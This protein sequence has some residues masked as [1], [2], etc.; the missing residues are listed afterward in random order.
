MVKQEAHPTLTLRRY[1]HAS[2]DV[3]VQT[4]HDAS[5]VGRLSREEDSC[6]AGGRGI[7]PLLGRGHGVELLLPLLPRLLG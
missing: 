1:V 3:H 2:P 5:Y 7:V 6:P 4:M